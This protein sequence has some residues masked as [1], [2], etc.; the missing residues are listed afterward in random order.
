MKGLDLDTI[1]GYAC[2]AIAAALGVL[3]MTIVVISVIRWV[4]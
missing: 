4:G 2:W 1:Q 3:V